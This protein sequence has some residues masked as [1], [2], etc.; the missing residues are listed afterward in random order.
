VAAKRAI[1]TNRIKRW[2]NPLSG[3][4]VLCVG[5]GYLQSHPL[6][7]LYTPENSAT[8]AGPITQHDFIEITAHK[9]KPSWF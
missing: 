2:P 8:A 3:G 9:T 7:Y 4:W 1:N 5:G 6:G